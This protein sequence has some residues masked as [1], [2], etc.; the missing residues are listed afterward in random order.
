MLELSNRRIFVCCQSVDM[1]KSFNG[2]SGI[3]MSDYGV[4][5]RS[6]DA[7]VFIGKRKNLLKVLVWDRDGFWC[8]AKRLSRGYYKVPNIETHT[9]NHCAVTMS[10][11][12]WNLLL[13][14]IVMRD[15]KQLP[16]LRMEQV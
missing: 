3:V 5:P 9:G 7:F 16:R 8:C 2:L 14:G 6:G 11:A 4:D 12:E 13:D 10:V 15:Y 1:R